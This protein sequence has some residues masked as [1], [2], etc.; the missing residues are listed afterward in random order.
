MDEQQRASLLE[1]LAEDADRRRRAF[2]EEAARQFSRF[3]DASKP[4]LRELDGL[5]LIDDD[6]EYLSVD[7]DG[8]F[9]SRTRYQDESGEWQ[10]ESEE[11]EDAADLVE[12]FNPADL[13]AAFADA[14]RDEAGLGAEPEGDEA[15][16]EET[17]ESPD[18]E[19]AESADGEED[20]EATVGDAFDDEWIANLPTPRDKPHAARL[21]YDLALT[22]QER[23]QLDQAELLDEFQ[24]ASARVAEVLGDSKVVEDE[25]ERIWFRASGAFEGEVMPERDESDHDAPEPDWQPLTT[26]DD[27]VQ[28]YD[29]TDLFGDLAESV[30]EAYPEV[31]PEL[32][33]GEDA[34]IA[35]GGGDR[36]EA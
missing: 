2:L 36:S 3:I 35:D 18:A 13:F 14:A 10:S 19:A 33:E 23:S 24:D 27:M 26:P 11:V 5:V 15:T 31:A 1:D 30:A 28:F 20:A 8:R 25:D 9:T 12:L 4:R 29:P 6:P 21:L 34:P 22:F 17:D 7:R 32:D 16:E